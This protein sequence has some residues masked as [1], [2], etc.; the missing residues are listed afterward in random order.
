L[1]SSPPDLRRQLS[2]RRLAVFGGTAMAAVLTAIVPG[3][4][5][6][7][8][9]WAALLAGA[10]L[11]GLLAAMLVPVPEPPD[12]PDGPDDPGRPTCSAACGAC[13][14]SAGSSRRRPVRYSGCC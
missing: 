2:A 4:P 13:C 9:L 10:V 1:A 12:D 14:G 7:A 6:T 5:A 8:L 11:A 3:L